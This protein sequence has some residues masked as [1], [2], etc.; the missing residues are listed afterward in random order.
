MI[1]AE[2]GKDGRGEEERGK[3]PQKLSGF[4]TAPRSRHEPDCSIL[5]GKTRSENGK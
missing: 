5:E 2:L 4:P 3:I 1:Y